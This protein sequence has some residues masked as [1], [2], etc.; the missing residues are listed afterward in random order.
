MYVLIIIAPYPVLG[1]AQNALHFIPG[2]PVHS[3]TN[4]TSLGS[5]SHAAM[6][7]RRLFI[8]I[9]NT[10]CSQILMSVV[11]P[12]GEEDIGLALKQQQENS[13]QSFFDS[14]SDVLTSRAPP[15]NHQG[16]S[17]E[18]SASPTSPFTIASVVLFVIIILN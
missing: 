15:N 11:E 3:N 18:N 12:R 1:T 16:I 9:S 17:Q 13:N 10:V 7:A 6:T 2:R 14:G 4:S 8:H 5:F